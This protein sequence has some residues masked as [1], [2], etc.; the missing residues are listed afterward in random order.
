MFKATIATMATLTIGGSNESKLLFEKQLI[1]KIAYTFE[2]TSNGCFNF[3]VSFSF[4][5]NFC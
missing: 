2:G 4:C 1:S 3:S 5:S